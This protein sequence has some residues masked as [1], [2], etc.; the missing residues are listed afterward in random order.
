MAGSWSGKHRKDGFVSDQAVNQ[1][2]RGASELAGELVAAGLWKRTKGGYRFHQWDQ[3]NPTASD[4]DRIADRKASGGALGNH[5]RWHKKKGKQ[6]PECQ[7]CQEKQASDDRSDK[8]S[9]TD[10]KS[11]RTPNPDPTRPEGS[12]TYS[13]NAG[14][15]EIWAALPRRRGDS[16]HKTELAYNAAIK[17]GVTHAEILAHATAYA[18]DRR[19]K[20]P[21]FTK[22]GEAWFNLRPWENGEP[23][24]PAR[25]SLWDN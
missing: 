12:T 6:N 8:G 25:R 16:R 13:N 22:G 18:A 21:Q 20:D 19:G 3:R 14:F 1:M 15:A 5:L 7:F 2:S 23:E 10:R 17:R 11:D 24:Q 9:D 4:A